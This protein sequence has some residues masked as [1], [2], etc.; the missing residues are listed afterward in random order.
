[1]SQK[2]KDRYYS[3]P[4][5]YQRQEDIR[6]QDFI[7]LFLSTLPGLHHIMDPAF[8]PKDCFIPFSSFVFVCGGWNTYNIK[9]T[10]VTILKSTVQWRLVH[11]QYYAAVTSIKLQN[12]VHHPQSNLFFS[13]C[14]S[15]FRSF[16]RIHEQI[17]RLIFMF[18]SKSFIVS[19]IITDL[20]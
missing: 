11:S 17:N 6:H 2:Y 4:S 20:L 1:M 9:F 12:N 18:S 14:C 13:F 15:C 7:L 8:H 3:Q 19:C 10:L 16:L 5:E